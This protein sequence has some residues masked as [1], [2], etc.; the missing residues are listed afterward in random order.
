MGRRVL[1]GP[2]RLG[3]AE[4]PGQWRDD[5]VAER[6]GERCLRQLHEAAAF[7]RRPVS[8]PSELRVARV[9]AIGAIGRGLPGS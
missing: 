4:A 6:A 7:V 5:V 3:A 8:W 9:P 1:G 2:E